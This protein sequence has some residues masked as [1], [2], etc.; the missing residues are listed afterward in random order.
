[1]SITTKLLSSSARSTSR[2]T[3]IIQKYRAYETGGALLQSATNAIELIS[4]VN[5][6][7]PGNGSGGPPIPT[8]GS[9]QDFILDSGTD[10]TLT[11]VEVV[12]RLDAC[13][14]ATFLCRFSNFRY[15]S[16]GGN[17]TNPDPRVVTIRPSGLIMDGPDAVFAPRFERR[18]VVPAGGSGVV[19]IWV[20]T[21]PLP[22]RIRREFL[23]VR[24]YYP[25]GISDTVYG[26]INDQIGYLH[27][28]SGTNWEFLGASARE[29]EGGLVAGDPVYLF[30]N[31]Q[32]ERSNG[33]LFENDPDIWT[34]PARGA[35][36]RYLSNYN[37]D[38]EP[39]VVSRIP[40]DLAYLNP[41]F[42]NGY[43]SFPEP[44][45]II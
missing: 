12:P 44:R 31:W 22:L 24:C 2:G 27:N 39:I 30:Y 13:D 34:L 11:C 26:Q 23:T 14:Y 6:A 38:N 37:E 32:T 3:Q 33:P 36:E 8:Q 17:P 42:P 5:D 10:I 43:L 29:A 4:I 15:W 21:E 18:R 9:S 7:L 19:T 28:F 40:E 41:N 20:R 45:P 1:M 16:G 25:N 35:F